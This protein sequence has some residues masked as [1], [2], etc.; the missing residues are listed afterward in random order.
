M[1]HQVT[2]V[3]NPLSQ[4]KL[5][6][7]A[8]GMFCH[9]VPDGLLMGNHFADR[10]LLLWQQLILHSKL[11]ILLELFLYT[12]LGHKLG[13]VPQYLFQEQHLHFQWF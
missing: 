10:R 13:I 11:Y 8:N 5:S 9:E 2:L 12:D 3:P 6:L 1:L 4:Q 7:E